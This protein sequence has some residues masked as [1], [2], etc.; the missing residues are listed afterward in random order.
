MLHRQELAAGW[1]GPRYTKPG[2]NGDNVNAE[3]EHCVGRWQDIHHNKNLP[4]S[5]QAP[6]RATVI[7]HGD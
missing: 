1:V 5:T 7:V 6:P 2:C 4:P 3:E